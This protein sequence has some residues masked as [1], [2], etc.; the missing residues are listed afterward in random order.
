MDKN[1]VVVV[2]N[3]DNIIGKELEETAHQQGILHRVVVV[4]IASHDGKILIQ[5]RNDGRLDHSCAGHVDPG[6][7]YESAAQRELMEELHYDAK[8]L[9]EVGIVVSRSHF[10]RIYKT[11]VDESGIDENQVNKNEVSRIEW[12]DPIATLNRMNLDIENKIFTRGFKATL[13]VYLKLS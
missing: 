12:A 5:L 1:Y 9:I 8:E 2:D 10:Y 7:N 6:E 13:K 3:N 11:I 4:Y